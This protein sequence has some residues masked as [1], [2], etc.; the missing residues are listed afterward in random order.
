MQIYLAPLQGLTDRIFRE[1]FS[2]HIALFDKTFAPFIRVQNQTF[3]RPSQC[4]DIVEANNQHQKPIPQFLG[5]DA[6][7]FRIFADLCKENNYSEVNI[8][9][10]CPYP[11]VTAKK[12]GAG[13]LPHPKMVEQLLSDIFRDTKLK[14]SV[15]CRLGLESNTEFDAL[16]PIFN[17]FPLEELVIHPRIGKQQYKGEADRD[18]F[19]K[20]AA[21]IKHSICYNGDIQSKTDMDSLLEKV[22]TLDKIM[23]GRGLLENPFLL[24][25]LHN[26]TLDKNQKREMLRGFHLRMME[27]CKE[28]YSGD[29]HFLK[30]MQELWS[31]QSLAFEDSH[32]VFKK[33]KKSRSFAQY[34][35][36]VFGAINNHI[37]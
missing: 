34:E 10:G 9:M 4:N 6:E 18:E 16:I 20:Q 5:N 15:K 28:K 29:T 27:L 3:Y 35:E 2:Q 11:M 37:K 23:I 7:S 12:M 30:S 21:K 24:H 32:K 26:I 8:N 1:S 33:V 13:I 14:I 17:D 22:P 19:V 36:A 25:E 31:Y